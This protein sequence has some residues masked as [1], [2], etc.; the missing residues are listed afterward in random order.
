MISKALSVAGFDPSSGAGIT[1]DL[2]VFRSLKV[3][4]LGII[5][6]IT[7]QNTSGV[8]SING[9]PDRAVAKQLDVLLEDIIPDSTKTGMILEKTTIRKLCRELDNGRISRLVLDPIIRSSTGK[10]L[11]KRDSIN[12]LMDELIPRS[13]I[14]TPNLYEASNISGRTIHDKDGMRRAAESIYR[15]GAK[16]VLLKGGHLKG[17]AV[18]ILYDGNAFK[19]Y[20]AKRVRGTFHGTGCAL[21]AAITAYLASGRN[22]KESVG[23]AKTFINRAIKG[24]VKPGKGMRILDI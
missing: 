10:L 16:N 1:A 17:D 23:R 8:R 15:L 5:T 2:K 11:I 18:D 13:L 4:G 22:L 3:Y 20:R 9:V 12:L 14:V 24:S 21:S 6:A 7:A 19:V